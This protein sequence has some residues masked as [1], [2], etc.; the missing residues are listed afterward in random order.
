MS[1]FLNYLYSLR[2]KGSSYGIERMLEFTQRLG[3]PQNSF[4]SI[5]VAGT[6]GKGSVCS[7]LSSIY[8]ENGYKVGMFTSPHLVELGERVQVN[9]E[10]L[11]FAEIERIVNEIRPVAEEM[12]AE[13]PGMHPTF[14]EVM[15]AVAFLTF[16]SRKVDLAVLETGLGGRLDST[17]VVTPELSVITSISLD[18]CEI[19]GSEIPEIAN[20]KAG[21]VK[22]GIPVL[23]GILPPDAF[24]VIQEV[25]QKRGAPHFDL[26][27]MNADQYPETNLDGYYQRRNAAL[28]QKSVQILNARFPIEKENT[29]R[30]LQKVKLPGRWQFVSGSPP[31][32]LDASHNQEGFIGLIENLSQLNQPFTAWIAAMGADRGKKLIEAITSFK[33]N[34]IVL[35]QPDQPRACSHKLLKSMI[36]NA[37]QGRISFGSWNNIGRELKQ[38]NDDPL[39]LVTGSIYLVGR[40]L[41]E[42][43]NRSDSDNSSLQDL[44]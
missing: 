31:L 2:N 35:F 1:D 17:N 42:I 24:L 15:T 11:S 30:G 10:I 19:L 33:P 38:C 34:R 40:V 43:D 41:S 4:P 14:F 44:V 21:I 26:M 25:A 5:H 9:G 39:V 18:H 16:Q 23:S 22:E 8:L 6:N 32:L 29:L 12:E 3:N 20:E 36:P 28:A 37:Y 13:K 7:M 27:N